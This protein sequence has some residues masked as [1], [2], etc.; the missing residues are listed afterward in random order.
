M[1]YVLPL[2]LI[3]GGMLAAAGL[4]VSKNPKAGELIAKLQPY[5]AII[6]I[7]LLVDGVYMLLVG[8]GISYLLHPMLYGLGSLGSSVG[9]VCAILL[10]LMFGMPM[11][12]RVSAGGAAK[13]AELGK[14]LAPYQ[15][16]IGVVAIASGLL[17]L[18]GVLGILH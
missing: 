4:I 10:G 6:G 13:G 8:Y 12:A 17:G 14:K 7:A 9:M 3:A 5:Q 11:L 1:F 2:L 18:L 16:I 15:T